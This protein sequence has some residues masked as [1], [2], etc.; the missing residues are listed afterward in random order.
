MPT[1][2]GIFKGYIPR[3]RKYTGDPRSIFKSDLAGAAERRLKPVSASHKPKKPSWLSRGL[4][5][6]AYGATANVGAVQPSQA[7]KAAILKGIVGAGLAGAARRRAAGELTS[8]ERGLE[9]KKELA[10]YRRGLERDPAELERLRQKHRKELISTT[11][12]SKAKAFGRAG[13]LE[14]SQ[15]QTADLWN[16]AGSV[17]KDDYGFGW[18]RLSD[19]QRDFYQIE[20]FNKIIAATKGKVKKYTPIKR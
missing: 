6:A 9:A 10:R 2:T 5:A 13:R 14:L 15:K 3:K 8:A 1:E 12:E 19:S 17:A 16:K 11:A 4:E 20:K 7:F 18:S